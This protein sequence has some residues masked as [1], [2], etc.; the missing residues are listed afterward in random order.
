MSWIRAAWRFLT[1]GVAF[2]RPRKKA[3][4]SLFFSGH[5]LQIKGVNYLLP[6][7]VP[8][9]KHGQEVVQAWAMNFN[10]LMEAL[11]ARK[12]RV[13]LYILDA[14]R[15]N[16]FRTDDGKKGFGASRGLADVRT[17]QGTFV[18]YSAGAN[19]QALDWLAEG[20]TD[21]NSVYTRRL[22]PLLSTQG[23]SLV[24]VS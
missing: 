24:E 7:D 22:L 14:C 12:P 4:R 18:M 1:H 3:T 17:P 20:R 8:D 13:S 21:P 9:A 10:E 11:E 5:G 6:S 23:L 15:D 2:W 19:E 16:P